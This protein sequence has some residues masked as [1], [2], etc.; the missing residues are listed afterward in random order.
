MSNKQVVESTVKWTVFSHLLHSHKLRQLVADWLAEDLPAF[1][2]GGMVVGQK[3]EN[4]VLLCKSQGVLAGME[5]N[6]HVY[7][8]YNYDN[9]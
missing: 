3:V 2:Y 7:V 9:A 1:D 6:T 5:L 4:A 8:G